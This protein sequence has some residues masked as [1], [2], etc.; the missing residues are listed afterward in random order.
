MVPGRLRRARRAA[1]V[2]PSGKV[3]RAALPSPD[4]VATPAAGRLRRAA[5]P[6][7]QRG[8]R[9]SSPRCSASSGSAHTT[10]SSHSAATRCSPTRLVMRLRRAFGVELSIAT[11]SRS[12]PSRARR[13]GSR[14]TRRRRPATTVDHRRDHPGAARRRRCRCRSRSNGCG[15]STSSNR[16]APSTSSRW[17]CGCAGPLD[18]GA[19]AGARWTRSSRG[20]R[21]CAPATPARGRRPRAARRPG[22]R[23]SS[24]SCVDV[25]R[26]VRHCALIDASVQPAVRP[27]RPSARCG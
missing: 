26:R 12:G 5:H 13:A 22:R 23:R 6:A 7:E 16:A 11:C 8:R 19:L 25:R 24:S 17:R 1:A 9:R 18:T 14:A 4:G 15:S 27:R 2:G 3:D 20:T 21:C 10:T